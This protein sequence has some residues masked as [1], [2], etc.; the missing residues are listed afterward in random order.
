MSKHAV[1]SQLIDRWSPY[2]FSP[3]P[4]EEEKLLSLFEA[5]RLAPSS[6]NEQPWLFVFTT[7]N[8]EK[9]F[10]IFLDFLYEGN[11]IWAVNA[12][13]L[14]IVMARTRLLRNNVVNR[15]AFY[16]TG[17]A[18]GNLLAQAT[19]LGLF[20]HQMGGFDVDA[21]KNHFRTGDLLEPLVIMAIG[22][23][24]D[25]KGLNEEIS[26]RDRARRPRKQLYEF[27]FR[28][29]IGTSPFSGDLKNS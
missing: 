20:V 13:V 23:Y 6:M 2:S 29:E 26:Q 4:V 3:V 17:M 24:G 15:H 8:E 25:G 28:N 21:V 10:K 1:I 16:D 9:F 7:R 14:T 12:P 11:R 27:V 5:A 22:Y 18:V 19:S